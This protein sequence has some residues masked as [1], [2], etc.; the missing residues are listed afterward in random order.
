MAS[1]REWIHENMCGLSLNIFNWI[2]KN[3]EGNEAVM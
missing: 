1:E 3:E 2:W